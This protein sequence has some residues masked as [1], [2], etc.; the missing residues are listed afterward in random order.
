MLHSH[1]HPTGWGDVGHN[2]PIVKETVAIDAMAASGITFK[3]FHTYP[4]CTPSRAQLLTGRLAPRTGVR[5]NF[6]PESLYG[7]PTTELTIAELLKPA[8]YDCLQ[9]GK[10]RF[11]SCAARRGAGLAR[12]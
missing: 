8:G 7:L 3:D 4:L 6:A 11:A 2:N 10:V 5:T 9:A 1:H 12:S